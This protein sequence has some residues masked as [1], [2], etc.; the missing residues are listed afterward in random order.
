MAFRRQTVTQR[1]RAI[2][3]AGKRILPTGEQ[4]AK[5]YAQRTQAWQ[6]EAWRYYHEIGEVWFGTELAANALRRL[7][8][9]PA[10]Q[11]APGEEP[12]RIEDGPLAA[13]AN[14]EL[15]RLRIG[16]GGGQLFHD[17]TVQL[18]IPA[19]CTLV[20][21]VEDDVER[22]QVFSHSALK[23]DSE[24]RWRV[25]QSPN[26]RDGMPLDPET[27]AMIRI[28][29]PDPEWPGLALGPMRPVLD[30]CDKMQITSRLIRSTM[31]NRI[32]LWGWL[33]IDSDASPPDMDPS[34]GQEPQNPFIND[35]MEAAETAIQNE[36]S[37]AA[38]LPVMSE[39]PGD[40]IANNRLI[41]FKNALDPE[42]VKQE[43]LNLQRIVN[44]MDYPKELI[45]GL[46]EG[47]VNFATSWQIDLQAFKAHLEPRAINIVESLT[48]GF[49]RPALREARV[50]GWEDVLI[51]YDPGAIISHPNQVA[52]VQYAYDNMEASGEFLR[53]ISN[54]PEDAKPTDD[55][56]NERIRR[57]QLSS[58]LALA[59][60][61]EGA[62][63]VAIEDAPIPPPSDPT[64]EPASPEA[65]PSGAPAANPPDAVTAAVA[66]RLG[67]VL[68]TIDRD[69]LIQL[70]V[71]ADD[72]VH[73]ALERSGATLR[74]K[75][76]SNTELAAKIRD[77][78][79][80]RVAFTLGR[81]T[82]FAGTT[83]DALLAAS[84]A[85]LGV[86]W[87]TLTARAQGRIRR[88]AAQNG[89]ITESDLEEVAVKQERDRNAGWD[90]LAALLL[91]VASK[92]LFSPEKVEP[93]I[94]EF[95]DAFTVQ[96]GV[97]RQALARAGGA[98]GQARLGGTVNAQLGTQPATGIT[99]GT[100]TTEL[101]ATAGLFVTSSTWQYNDV[102][103]KTFEPHLDLDGVDFVN[104]DD[105]ALA[106]TPEGDW[107]GENFYAPGDHPGCMC[108][109]I[110]SYESVPV[111]D[112]LLPEMQ[113]A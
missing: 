37:A 66:P 111:D 82:S 56:I 113:T 50:A 78:P 87:D 4:A 61:N 25:Y 62:T 95:D 69:L 8:I 60:V 20:G 49:L 94:G 68:A 22:W 74:R 75:A 21:F 77:V 73:R 72:T 17:L 83:D 81:K 59:Q 33:L 79:N 65:P 7:Q 58:P 63:P 64:T 107:I 51:W 98:E 36:G 104:W 18:D 80:E 19:D 110:P 97:I 23:L 67:R 70:Q 11:P 86:K 3:A 99:S 71:A 112:D 24:R 30:A 41:E 34:E 76:G 57:R 43:S 2:T 108:D 6:A 40:R 16:S 103:Q 84:I 14:A 46:G 89:D 53:D 55:E 105:P 31:R 39:M 85:A 52:E 28:W 27:T 90:V 88:L 91:A 101:M 9:F 100:T 10:I 45:L 35:F 5:Q 47:H 13:A 102:G 15:D 29:R 12:V 109:V 1:P 26:D 48:T 93:L 96:S 106:V 42:V 32:A 44:G 38:M 54:I 92:K